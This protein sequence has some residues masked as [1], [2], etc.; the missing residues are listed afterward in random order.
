MVAERGKQ[1][2]PFEAMDVL[3]RANALE[4][5]VHLEVGEPDFDPPPAAIDAAAESMHSGNTE[6][7]EARGKPALRAAIVE[8]YDQRYGVDV[9][10]DQIVVTPGSSP[11]LLLAYL[12]SLDPGDHA[13]ITDPFY[14]CYPNFI[15]QAGG[16]ITTVPLDPT[17]GFMPNLDEFD[18]AIGPETRTVM[19]NS[20]ANPTGAV[21][22]DADLQE[23]TAITDRANATIISDEAYHGL[24]Y[25]G[26]A[27]SILEYTDAAF[28]VDTFS[29]RFGM[30]G[31]RLGWLVTPPE[32]ADVCNRLAQN[33]FICAP[34]F[35]QD[36]GIAAL[37]TADEFV[38]AKRDTYRQRRDYL[39]DAVESLGISLDYVP[40]GA[41]YLL[42]DVRQFGEAF[43][44]ANT[45]LEDA[46]VATTPGRD[47][48]PTASPFLRLSYA[49]TLENLRDA[50]GRIENTLGRLRTDTP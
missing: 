19:I 20:P 47:F 18:R 1:T 23:L 41:Y 31:W 14:A 24:A 11:A 21:L 30:T 17:K 4:D 50:T 29:K 6:Y 39:L 13:V 37:E 16:D 5:V 43:D 42:V 33:L 3:E 46:G 35:V 12:A 7:T 22:P 28:V 15:R 9:S 44:V 2:T 32:V 25:G 10:M 48:G 26:R 34:S 36:A 27:A 40:G 8:Y 45:L 38:P 49:T